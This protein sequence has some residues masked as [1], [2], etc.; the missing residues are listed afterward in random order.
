MSYVPSRDIRRG[1]KGGGGGEVERERMLS[2]AVAWELEDEK[3][4]LVE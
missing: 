4:G 2:P 1:I 3:E